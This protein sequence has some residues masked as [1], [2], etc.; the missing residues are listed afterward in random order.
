MAQHQI[1][2]EGYPKQGGIA[3]AVLLA[4]IENENFQGACLELI[5]QDEM[6]GKYF[7]RRNH[8]FMGCKIFATEEKARRRWG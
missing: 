1:W 8:M 6:F 2:V 4:T 3:K 5:K 7:D